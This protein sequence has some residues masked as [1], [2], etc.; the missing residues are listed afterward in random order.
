LELALIIHLTRICLTYRLLILLQSYSSYKLTF[1]IVS[2]P[3][4]KASINTAIATILGA[5]QNTIVTSFN[6]EDCR[7]PIAG[8]Y[9]CYLVVYTSYA[10]YDKDKGLLGLS[11]TN[12]ITAAVLSKTTGLPIAVTGYQ[13]EQPSNSP[14]TLP[15]LA[16]S[17]GSESSSSD[18]GGKI[19]KRFFSFVLMMAV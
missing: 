9:H 15:V 4:F 16:A 1:T 13:F 6:P 14:T 5:P 10:A 18:R 7:F 2:S 19:L 11:A 8:T 17:P 12:E 3:A